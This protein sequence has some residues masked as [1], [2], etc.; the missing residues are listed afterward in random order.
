MEHHQQS[1]Y[2]EVQDSSDIVPSLTI[3]L[4][5]RKFSTTSS[6]THCSLSFDSNRILSKTKN[7]SGIVDTNYCLQIYYTSIYIGVYDSHQGKLNNSRIMRIHQVSIVSNKTKLYFW[8]NLFS[9]CTSFKFQ[10]KQIFR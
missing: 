10:A 1:M 9:I 2:E 6:L 8:M 3:L 5:H 4:V 7:L